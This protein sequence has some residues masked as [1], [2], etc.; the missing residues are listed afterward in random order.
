M[1]PAMWWKPLATGGVQCRL[2]PFRCVIFEG[3]RGICGVR[4]VVNDTLRALTFSRAASLNMDPIEKKPLFHYTPGA[5]AL[6][7]ATYGCNLSCNFCQN[8]TLSQARP[9][10]SPSQYLPPEKVV[11]IALT[12]G[13]TTIAYTYSEPTIF[14][15]YMFETA[16]LAHEAGI[17]NLWITCGYINEEPLRELCKYLDAANVDLKSWSND[18]YRDYLRATR[19]PVLRTLKILEEEGVWVEVT[20]LLIPEANDDPEDIRA[21]CRWIADSLGTNVPLHFSRFHPNYK[22]TD[23]PATPSKTL[24]M[25]YDIAKEEGLEYVY[26]GNVP[27]DPHEDTYCPV[28][29]KKIIDRTGFWISEYNIKDGCCGFCG[30]RINGVFKEERDK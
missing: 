15:E 9:E 13:A 7:I 22:L 2:C 12:N 23:R 26:V 27:G 5:K 14:Y 25:A 3:E 30:A 28:C 17:S 4:A 18:F 21:L 1:K 6:S 10:D 11:E 29:G 16:V 24:E 20:N 19:D 8:W